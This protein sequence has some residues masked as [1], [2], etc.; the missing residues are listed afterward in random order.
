MSSNYIVH[1]KFCQCCHNPI[2]ENDLECPFCGSEIDFEEKDY[3]SYPWVLV[4]T[5]NTL[6]EAEMYK[7]NLEGAGIPVNILSQVDTSRMLTVGGL[8]IV[9][10]FVKSPFVT[11]AEE[12]IKEINSSI[13]HNVS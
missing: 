4:Y 2:S 3:S 1:N 10:I 9:K 6:I 12:I 13:N 11:L 7:A 8:A 5:T